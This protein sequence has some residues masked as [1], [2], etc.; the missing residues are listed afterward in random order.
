MADQAQLDLREPARATFSR[1]GR[2]RYSLRR[3]TGIDNERQCLWIML[4]PSTADAEQDDPTIRKVVAFARS[5]GYGWAVVGNVYGFRST[6]PTKLWKAKD[7]VGSH[8]DHMLAGLVTTAD[9]VVCGW[10]KHAKP[11]RVRDV[12]DLVQRVRAWRGRP[13]WHCLALNNDGS[14][15]HPLYLSGDLKPR[16]FVDAA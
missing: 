7:P 8:N 1:C 10:G 6:D 2:Y 15:R 9:L 5:W 11:G 13:D 4:N 3:R 12:A 16:R 14:P